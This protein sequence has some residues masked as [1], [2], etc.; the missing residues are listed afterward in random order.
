MNTIPL[1]LLPNTESLLVLRNMEIRDQLAY[2][3]C[4]KNTKK[5]IKSLNLKA[6]YINITVFDSVRAGIHLKNLILSWSS[7]KLNN[8]FL[9]SQ[10]MVHEGIYFTSKETNDW[11]WDLE[12]YEFK[13]LLHHFCEVFHHPKIDYFSIDG[14]N[15]DDNCIEPIQSVIKGIQIGR[16]E[17]NDELTNDFAEKALDSFPNYEKLGLLQIP[18][19][20]DKQNK[21][22]I[23]NLKSVCIP[24]A[25]EI[26]IN[27]VLLSNSEIIQ[28][29]IS[30]FN[31]KELNTFMKLWIRG[32]NPR[33]KYFYTM[34]QPLF[35]NEFLDKTAVLR[36]IKYVQVPLDSQEVY[37]L[38][39]YENYFFERKLAGGFRIWRFDGTTAVI[40][41]T[42]SEFE[43][44]VE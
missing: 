13:D 32:S 1:H 43:F 8:V 3:L 5:S 20:M 40:V 31:E 19:R 29:Y 26:K 39:A 17:I 11:K 10:V 6:Q 16:L 23:Q 4:S 21:L 7:M 35:G 36:G 25:D 44:I 15:L 30:N 22:L 28:L 38:N 41:V 37:L 9:S 18:F 33:L 24:G 34:G 14:E 12:N 2:S 27:Q 42:E